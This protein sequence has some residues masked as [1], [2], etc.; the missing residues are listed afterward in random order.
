[1]ALT[2]LNTRSLPDN[3]ITTAKIA[4]DAVATAK[5]ANNAVTASKSTQGYGEKNTLKPVWQRLQYN[6]GGNSSHRFMDNYCTRVTSQNGNNGPAG[7]AMLEGSTGTGRFQIEFIPGYQWGW[8]G[9]YLTQKEGVPAYDATI[10]DVNDNGNFYVSQPTGYTQVWLA[11]NSSNNVRYATF[12]NGSSSS[13]NLISS[14]SGG[15][16]GATWYVWRDSSGLLRVSDSVTTT[17]IIASGDTTD[18]I[19]HSA[20]GQSPSSC[21]IIMAQRIVP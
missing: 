19:V 13:G 2:K 17:T 4:N 3:A 20:T 16:N 7:M 11:N 15:T 5:I 8:S 12:W 1:M 9:L 6:A 10:D 21:Q 18:Y 14:S